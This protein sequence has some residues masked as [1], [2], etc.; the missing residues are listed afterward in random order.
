MTR[1]APAPD[2]LAS[3]RAGVRSTIGRGRAGALPQTTAAASWSP[4][5]LERQL[6]S[7]VT[8]QALVL[9]YQPQFNA[10]TGQ[11]LGFEAL[12]RWEHPELGLLLPR[13]FL[14]GAQG[15]VLTELTTL[16]VDRALAD[17]AALRALAPGATLAVN[18]SA[19]HLL[20]LSLVQRLVDQ[21]RAAGQDCSSVVLELTEP[22]TV[23][24]PSTTALLAALHEHGVRVSIRN[25]S[26]EDAGGFRSLW[27]A[28]AVRE[29][30]IDP[31]TTTALL[32]D[33]VL[34]QQVGA[35]IRAARALDVRTVAEGVETARAVPKLRSLG[36]DVL[37]G[38]WLAAPVPLV[39]LARSARYWPAVRRD[40]QAARTTVPLSRTPRRTP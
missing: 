16:V 37:Q 1:R 34:E 11:V 8:S 29:M 23:A 17:L 9:H 14:V 20:D 30:K 12:A 22:T 10:V 3:L 27:A 35:M 7:A 26:V 28:P 5:E 39:E 4:A 25:G 18:G 2:R 31:A 40:I 19:H 21:V 32:D 24:T 36:V 38:Y 6:R 15:P 33:P 13:D